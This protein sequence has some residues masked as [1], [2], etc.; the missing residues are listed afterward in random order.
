A[1]SF[2]TKVP[3]VDSRGV[4]GYGDADFVQMLRVRDAAPEVGLFGTAG[5]SPSTPI[6]TPLVSSRGRLLGIFTGYKYGEPVVSRNFVKRRMTGLFLGASVLSRAVS[7]IAEYGRIR[8]GFLGIVI[9]ASKT[10][11]RV[12]SVIKGSPASTGGLIAGDVISSIDGTR[13]DAARLSREL[14]LRRPGDRVVLTVERLDQDVIV[15][16]GNRAQEEAQWVGPQSLGL[17]VIELGPSLAAYLRLDKGQRGVV[18][19]RIEV[20][21]IAELAGLKRGDVV[22]EGGGGGIADVAEFKAALV[23]SRGWIELLV[24]RAGE[25][26]P[27]AIAIRAPAGSR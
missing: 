20:D 21:S 12:A 4:L 13:C 26:L 2:E 24:M 7:D 10:G 17:E 8:R 6:G 18:V 19:E 25:S 5:P 22:I 27:L 11:G 23:A 16:L 3:Q 14:A 9:E 1:L 15:T